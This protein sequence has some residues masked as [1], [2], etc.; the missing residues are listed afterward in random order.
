M[1]FKPFLSPPKLKSGSKKLG[2]TDVDIWTGVLL[3]MYC[4]LYDE[5]NFEIDTEPVQIDDERLPRS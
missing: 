1:I 4:L 3:M 5:G 2:I